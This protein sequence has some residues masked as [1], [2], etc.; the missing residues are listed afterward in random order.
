MRV[1]T[2]ALDLAIEEYEGDAAKT[3]VLLHGFPYDPRAWDGVA[4]GL[5]AGGWRVLVPYLRGHGPTRFLD[6]TTLRSGEQAVLGADLI[7]MMDALGLRS[8]ILAGY[9]WGGRAACIAAA[10]RPDLVAGLVTGNGY[11][12]FGD[13]AR[14]HRFEAA[15]L[16]RM[17]YAYVLQGEAGASAFRHDPAGFARYLWALWSPDWRFT[18]EDFA[19]SA[20]SFANPDYADVVIHSYRHR[21]GLVAG[22]PA[23]A[24]LVARLAAQPPIAVPTIV[25]HGASDTVDPPDGM[26]ISDRLQDVRDHRILP[27]VGHNIPQEAPEAVLQAISALL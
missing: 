8:A 3:A 9:D 12:I 27:G 2:S 7:E 19:R 4:A 11:N 26:R 20:P 6:E 18:A 13:P 21:A 23:V 17:W 25:L 22:D 24:G 10:T 5:A 1:R 15:T 14:Y 16:H